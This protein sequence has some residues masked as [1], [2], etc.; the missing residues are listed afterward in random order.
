M[1]SIGQDATPKSLPCRTVYLTS[2]LVT[3][4]LLAAYSA[5]LI[6]FLAA[7]RTVMPFETLRDMLGDETYNLYVPSGN[8]LNFFRVSNFQFLRAY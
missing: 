8:E 6:S 1:T 3:V 2:Y 5:A 4:V 7:K